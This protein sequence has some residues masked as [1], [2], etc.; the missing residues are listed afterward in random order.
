MRA[1]VAVASGVIAVVVVA[2]CLWAAEPA[3][4]VDK[5]YAQWKHGPPGDAD[6]FPIAVYG[7]ST[8]RAAEFR[9]LGFNVYVGSGDGPTAGDLAAL[10]AAGMRLIC[11]QNAVALEHRDEAT[12][13][14][15]VGTDQP[16]NAQ[17]I[18]AARY[19]PPMT[20]QEVVGE[21][22]EMKARDATRPV[23][24][25]FGRGAAWDKWH[26][27]GRR[28]NH[29]EDYP[30]Y[31]AGGD[32]L[33]FWIAPASAVRKGC[34]GELHLIPTGV[35]R[36]TAW[37]D[38]RKPVW[39]GVECTRVNNPKRKAT[40]HEVRAEVWMSII[41]GSRG[42]VYPVDQNKPEPVE[43]ALLTDA[44]MAASVKAINGQVRALAAVVNSPPVTDGATV[45]SVNDR[46]PVD[47]MVRRHGGAVY[48]FAA[49]MR[50]DRTTAAFTVGGLGPSA[51]VDVLG[52]RRRFDI[53]GGTFEDAFEAYDV[54]IYKITPGGNPSE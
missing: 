10:K 43:A 42:L 17:R 8:A 46:V 37:S 20:P 11:R 49:A 41:H 29:P 54:H 7:Q 12:I 25:R 33:C 28:A 16:D 13:I 9:E 2:T 38:G 27:R 6:F 39:S 5:P 24:L 3:V 45:V 47:I 30:G 52:E 15:W 1:R 50:G 19:G 21:Y 31:V 48:V 51:T 32:I 36:L 35:D 26:G 44:A 18:E 40:P 53:V 14:G 22:Q 34:K 4:G 23:F